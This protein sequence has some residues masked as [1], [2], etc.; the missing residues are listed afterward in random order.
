MQERERERPI[1]QARIPEPIGDR[2]SDVPV[3]QILKQNIEAAKIPEER[4]QPR[5][6]E[7]LADV[8]AP[9]TRKEIGEKIQPS[10]PSRTSDHICEQFVDVPVPQ[11]LDSVAE[12]VEVIPAAGTADPSDDMPVL[13][14][15]KEIG[16]A[17][18]AHSG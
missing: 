5:A 4:L 12:V 11:V 13:Q 3:T 9:Q 16:E 10:L 8:P 6:E 17:I 15:R 18:P 2:T 14:I 7:H 1:P